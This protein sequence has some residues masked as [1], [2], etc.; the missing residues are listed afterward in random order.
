MIRSNSRLRVAVIELTGLWTKWVWAT[1]RSWTCSRKK[2]ITLIAQIV[3]VVW[4]LYVC[5]SF[6]NWP[7]DKHQSLCHKPLR[8]LAQPM[9]SWERNREWCRP[10]AGLCWRKNVR[11]PVRITWRI[12]GHVLMDYR[13]MHASR[14]NWW[15]IC[16]QHS[17][18]QARMCN[19][20]STWWGQVEQRGRSYVYLFSYITV[21]R[22]LYKNF[23]DQTRRCLSLWLVLEKIF[24]SMMAD[25][26][27]GVQNKNKCLRRV[28][29]L[30]AF[31]MAWRW[32]DVTVWLSSWRWH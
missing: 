17:L 29:A 4:T 25:V 22:T 19:H 31:R 15:D 18:G 10:N 1:Q 8:K 23:I 14:T 32:L 24:Q 12:S 5:V 21:G 6:R 26:A 7:W 9:V 2:V 13:Y 28:G 27:D 3:P 11:S 30:A 20:V 16:R